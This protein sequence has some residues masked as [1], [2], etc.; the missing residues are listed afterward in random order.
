M[1]PLI[2]ANFYLINPAKSKTGFILH[3]FCTTKQIYS[4]TKLPQKLRTAQSLWCLLFSNPFPPR[5]K[6]WRRSPGF[7]TRLVNECLPH[8]SAK[9]HPLNCDE[10]STS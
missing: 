4:S 8:L 7:R 6:G 3:L 10:E 2:V 1:I 9:H 5:I